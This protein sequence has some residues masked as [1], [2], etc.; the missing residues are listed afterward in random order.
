[1]VDARDYQSRLQRLDA[2]LQGIDR[3]ADTSARAQMR[4]IVASLLELHGLGL[5]RMLEH[6]A[7]AGEQGT[8]VLDAC[9]HDDVSGG[10]LL[11]H[12]LHPMG[13]RERV[14]LALEEARR[15]LRSHGG[16]VELLDIRDGVA[17]LRLL[18]NCH[19]CPSSAAT[20]KQTVEDALIARAPDLDA[21]EVEG[22]RPATM[23]TPDGRTL[24][25]LS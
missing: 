23:T 7:A 10:L 11:L 12:G 21:I 8:A 1:M 13:L 16:D 18:G 14:L 15:H 20:L 22:E 24:V 25:V 4:E 9:A 2:L 6:V 3:M 19:G 17:R 5:E